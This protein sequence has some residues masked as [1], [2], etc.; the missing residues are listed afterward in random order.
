MKTTDGGASWQTVSVTD[1]PDKSTPGGIDFLGHKDG[2]C[3]FNTNNGIVTGSSEDNEIYAYITRDCGATWQKQNIP[4]PNSSSGACCH[5]Y[6]PLVFEGGKILLPVINT[7]DTPGSTYFYMSADLG[8]TWT[9][10]F[11]I[12]VSVWHYCFSSD[13][14]NGYLVDGLSVFASNKGKWDRTV[15]S[16]PFSAA[17]PYKMMMTGDAVWLVCGGSGL[18][19]STDEGRNWTELSSLNYKH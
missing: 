5:T 17:S 18:L 10:S 11:Q 19:K 16:V 4:S 14:T 12:P 2:I 13:G 3:F 1:I 15:M 7:V 8:A 6:Q 9:L